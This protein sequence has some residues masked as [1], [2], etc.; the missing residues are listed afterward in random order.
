MTPSRI[1]LALVDASGFIC[2]AAANLGISRDAV[3]WYVRRARLSALLSEW[4]R[5]SGWNG[6]RPRKEDSR[7]RVNGRRWYWKHRKAA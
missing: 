2:R 7:K 3:S 6:G 1:R 5:A 4:R